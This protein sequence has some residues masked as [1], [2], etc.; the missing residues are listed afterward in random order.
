MAKNTIIIGVLVEEQNS[1]S[2][3]EICE[4]Y[5]VS[6]S[7][8]LDILNLGLIP[9]L[10]SVSKDLEFDRQTFERIKI[11]FRLQEDL[12]LNAEGVVLAIELLDEVAELNRELEVLKR[13]ISRW[14][15]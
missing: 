10:D 12:G 7:Q 11:A 15:S 14:S 3:M 4:T 5:Q 2:F 8:L 6:E 1:I 13:H 9:S